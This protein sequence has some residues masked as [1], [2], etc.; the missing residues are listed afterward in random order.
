[1]NGLEAVL[2]SMRSHPCVLEVQFRALFALINL[3]IPEAVANA[4]A[5]DAHTDASWPSQTRLPRPPTRETNDRVVCLVLAAMHHFPESEKLVRCGCLVLHNLSLDESNISD[6]I[7]QGVS[8]PLF[9]AARTHKDVD[10]QRSAIST[11]RRLGF[12]NLDIA[13]TR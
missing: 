5:H 9:C 4:V 8:H 13:A 2:A 7:T 11:L 1:M 10:V 3:V 6:L 12:D